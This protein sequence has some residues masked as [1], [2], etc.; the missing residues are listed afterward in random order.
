M[1]DLALGD[2]DARL[3]AMSGAVEQMTTQIDALN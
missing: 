3:G 1:R 2:L